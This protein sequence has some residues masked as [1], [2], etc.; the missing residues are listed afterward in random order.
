MAKPDRAFFKKIIELAGVPAPAIAYVGDRLDN[1][2]LAREAGLAAIFIARGPWGRAHA[3]RPEI[4]A[5]SRDCDL[6]GIYHGL[7]ASR[8]SNLALEPR[9][10]KNRGAK[11]VSAMV[12]QPSPKGAWT[13]TVLV[14]FFML[15]NFADKIVVGPAGVRSW[16]SLV[17]RHRCFASGT[18]GLPLL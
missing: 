5:A 10:P 1:D 4:A 2:I 3:R 13:V 17:Q 14:F 12:E 7:L 18:L 11:S 15:V 9:E 6:G 16:Q 8:G